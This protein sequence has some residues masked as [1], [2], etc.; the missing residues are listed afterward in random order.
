MNGFGKLEA[1]YHE[2][3][4]QLFVRR[5]PKQHDARK[6]KKK[7]REIRTRSLKFLPHPR[8]TLSN[9]DKIHVSFWAE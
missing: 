1:D 7:L 9:A 6:A 4:Q 5:D 8:L 2:R 3:P